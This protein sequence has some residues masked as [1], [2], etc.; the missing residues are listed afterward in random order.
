MKTPSL[1]LFPEPAP[2]STPP[3]WE[4][5]ERLALHYPS[6]HAY[7]TLVERG[8]LTREQALIAM[9]HW[10]ATAFSR[11][12]KRET[13]ALA[14]EA[15]ETTIASGCGCSRSTYVRRRVVEFRCESHEAAVAVDPPVGATSD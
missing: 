1:D 9:V 14:C 12:F 4:D 6:A 7:V 10:F 13:D 11:Q 8:D 5:I 15:P 2:P 3:T